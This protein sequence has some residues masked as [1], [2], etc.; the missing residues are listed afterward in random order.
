MSQ[1]GVE[2]VPLQCVKCQN[3]ILAQPD[4]VLWVCATCGQ[5]QMLSDE[6]GLVAQPVHYAAGIAP[7][8]QGKPVWVVSAQVGLHRETY[9]GDESLSML[10]FWQQPRPFFIPAYTL[11]LDQLVETCQ[12]MLRQPAA[13]QEV[14]SRSAFYPV[15]VHAEDLQAL[16][17]YIVLAVEADRSDMLKEL[18]FKV[19]L[20]QPELWIVP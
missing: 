2:L 3:P 4:E 20:G 13:L 8:A 6:H 1:A 18:D 9:R 19:Q 15:T 5:G 11:P 7:N 12:R 14:Q 16:V 10:Q 17:E